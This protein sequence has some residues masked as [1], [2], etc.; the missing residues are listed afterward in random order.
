MRVAV[1]GSSGKVG[2]VLLPVLEGRG[3]SVQRGDPLGADV[4]VDF[5]T[6]EAVVRN[7]TQCVS[8]GVPV[9]GLTL[10]V[11]GFVPCR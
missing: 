6:P 10:G 9:V 7:V 3:W 5:T 1:Y 8:L 4:A 11:T 2:R